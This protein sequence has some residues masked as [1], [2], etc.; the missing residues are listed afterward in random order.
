MKDHL[1]L[2]KCKKLREIKKTMKYFIDY[3]N[4]YRYQWDLKKDDFYRIQ[5]SSFFL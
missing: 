5:K 2:K 1:E 4:N 3:Y